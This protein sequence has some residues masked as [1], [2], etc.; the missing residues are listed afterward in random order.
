MALRIHH[1]P[2]YQVTYGGGYFGNRMAEI[3]RLLYDH[4]S[5]I[6]FHGEDVE[7]SEWLAIPRADLVM[8]IAEIANDK[9]SFCGW[10]K[11]HS[12]DTTTEGFIS[13]ICKWLTE[14]DPRNEF[15]V[16][17]WF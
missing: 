17:T 11:S 7:S 9:E 15:V 8:L 12:V 10:L 4:S 14:S 5:D 16:L 2:V 3:N 13:I 6:Q 1:S